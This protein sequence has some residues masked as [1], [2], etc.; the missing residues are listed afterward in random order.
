MTKNKNEFSAFSSRKH[1]RWTI[2]GSRNREV[3]GEVEIDRRPDDRTVKPCGGCWMGWGGWGGPW[4][5]REI[6]AERCISHCPDSF[7]NRFFYYVGCVF[8]EALNWKRTVRHRGAN[9]TR[10]IPLKSTTCYSPKT[11]PT[12]YPF[13]SSYI[14]IFP[15]F[16]SPRDWPI[17]HIL[18]L[19]AVR[20]PQKIWKATPF[21][22]QEW[23]LAVPILSWV[24]WR[25]G[26]P[27][28]F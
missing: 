18:W 22:I 7:G 1:R 20:L 27:V 5:T 19:A 12:Y 28:I 16:S 23:V 11:L 15:S 24:T 10:S 21:T 17:R 13:H 14:F 6:P 3:G 9:G 2:Q 4:Y 26:H 25:I 8:I